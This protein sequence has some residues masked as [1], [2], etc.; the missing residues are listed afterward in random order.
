MA[1]LPRG[2]R[3]LLGLSLTLNLVAAGADSEVQRVKGPNVV[4]RALGPLMEVSGPSRPN[5]VREQR[6]AS[7]CV[8]CSMGGLHRSAHNGGHSSREEVRSEQQYVNGQ[9]VYD[10]Y[11]ERRFQ[12]GRI[13]HDRREE[14]DEDDLGYRPSSHGTNSGQ[15]SLT[16][17][18]DSRHNHG[19]GT[20]RNPSSSG[21]TRDHT[22]AYGSDS[23]EQSQSSGT[24]DTE[25]ERMQENMRRQM[26][27]F[28]SQ[29]PT[30]GGSQRSEYS[31]KVRY[32]N[33]QPVYEKK[34]ERKYK[35]GELVHEDTQ[36][37]GP[38]HF[39]TEDVLRRYDANGALI[40]DGSYGGDAQYRRWE[41]R[42]QSSGPTNRPTHTP[43]YSSFSQDHQQS[44]STY[45]RHR[46]SI[47]SSSTRNSPT[48]SSRPTYRR[49]S[50]YNPSYNR[51]SS[52]HSSTEHHSSSSSSPY[53]PYTPTYTRPSHQDARESNYGYN[54]RE[55]TRPSHPSGHSPYPTNRRPT[56]PNREYSRPHQRPASGE[57][58]TH[59]RSEQTRHS[60]SDSDLTQQRPTYPTDDLQVTQVQ[61]S[62]RTPEDDHPR[63]QHA[64]HTAQSSLTWEPSRVPN[65]PPY[66]DAVNPSSINREDRYG[67][68]GQREDV[69]D[70]NYPQR[71]VSPSIGDRHPDSNEAMGESE[72]DQLQ[73]IDTD[74]DRYDINPM[75]TGELPPIPPVDMEAVLTDRY[76]NS[77]EDER[78]DDLTSGRGTLDHDTHRSHSAISSDT[79]HR[80]HVWSSNSDDYGSSRGNVAGDHTSPS[81]RAR[82]GYSLTSSHEDQ[83]RTT[84]NT[85]PVSEGSRRYQY[86]E[87]RRHTSVVNDKQPHPED[88]PC[89][90]AN[91]CVVP[92]SPLTSS[93][94][95]EVRTVYRYVNGRLVGMTQH[96]RRY[97]NGKMV[98][99]NTTEH[100]RNEVA[101]L[102]LEEYGMGQLDLPQEAIR[103]GIYSQQHEV[104]EEKEYADG[105]QIYDLHQERHFEDGNLVFN[106]R[107]E[108]DEDDLQEMGQAGA[109]R[110][111]IDHS[112]EDTMQ[113][114]HHT[115]VTPGGLDTSLLHQV[116]DSRHP[117]SVPVYDSRRF[118]SRQEQEFVNG[119]QVYD[120]N[121][122]RR[123]RN[124]SLVYD[125]RTEQNE[126]DLSGS[127][128]HDALHS[129]LSGNTL[130]TASQ[131]TYNRPSTSPYSSHGQSQESIYSGESYG[132]VSQTSNTYSQG[133]M[134]YGSHGRNTESD[135]STETYH[136]LNYNQNRDNYRDGAR[137]QGASMTSEDRSTFSS[138]SQGSVGTDLITSHGQSPGSGRASTHVLGGSDYCHRGSRSLT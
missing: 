24:L 133:R 25:F 71:R 121:H 8:S 23:H 2:V 77:A 85:R 137:T 87:T 120:L 27:S 52:E 130:T 112:R 48:Y 6:E 129:I 29:Q 13:V 89:T 75:D 98:Y 125:N 59:Y 81:H 76:T 97:K 34:E 30:Y 62:S 51:V 42:R 45:P 39:G 18:S 22:Q 128:H 102:N 69:L 111:V 118:E 82:P 93:R 64:Q 7:P 123:Y 138:T 9:P 32:V 36:E 44:G 15:S 66:E 114:R 107:V 86:N 100:G 3:L 99:D 19:R 60:V 67:S 50:S 43:R 83:T 116:P 17:N 16:R 127:P 91:G 73:Q 35:D 47:D 110:Q 108:L 53:S 101:H 41:T 31:S 58:S 92:G 135:Q 37:K 38:E 10:M 61:Q 40:T 84:S 56:T 21:N 88:L 134:P 105:Q 65:K 63:R 104:K 5:P 11:H 79:R 68:Y 119:Q 106:N 74:D 80:A 70:S 4:T 136:D 90:R 96:E 78:E 1:A 49:P 132:D 131:D 94:R 113:G 46:P 57:S 72:E 54:L 124:G 55:D 117:S 26:M 122:E 12:D 14:R 103:P 28:G 126:D 33:G 115:T 95:S 109:G 20:Y